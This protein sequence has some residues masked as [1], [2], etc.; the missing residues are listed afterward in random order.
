MV[1][2]VAMSKYA[3]LLGTIMGI[4]LGVT[5]IVPFLD[6]IRGKQNVRIFPESMIFFNI[7]C[8]HLWCAYWV[9]Q[10]VFIPFFS[11]IF[12]LTLGLIFSTIY[13]Y[14]YLD[15]NTTKWLFAL[16]VKFGI[17]FGFHYFL[18][19]ILPSYH[20]IG[21]AAMLVGIF[22]SIAP[23]QNVLTVIK[24]RDYKLIPICST[25][26]GSLCNF[27][28][29]AFGVM[30]KDVYNIIPNAICFAINVSNTC[31]WLYFY[32]TR[33]QNKDKEEKEEELKDEDN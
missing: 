8:P 25:V 26:F 27:F 3:S 2:W 29:L 10:A 24:K 33:D 19:Y 7:L 13:I 14:F 28:W 30:L 31:I 11:A 20:Y 1:D 4:S 18:L 9:R 12:G 15:K 16:A 6:I 17:V 5:P 32:Y 23:A 22:T 21:F